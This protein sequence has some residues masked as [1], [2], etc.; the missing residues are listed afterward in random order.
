MGIEYGIQMLE[1]VE[2]NFTINI[3]IIKITKQKFYFTLRKGKIHQKNGFI[4]LKI[5]HWYDIL[6]L[7]G[8]YNLQTLWLL[9]MCMRTP[10]VPTC[11]RE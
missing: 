2:L 6:V 9:S 11:L 5:T 1:V 10:V 3:N 4:I 7:Y 8:A